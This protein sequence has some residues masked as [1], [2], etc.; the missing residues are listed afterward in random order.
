MSS[1]ILSPTHRLKEA[2]SPVGRTPSELTAM[3]EADLTVSDPGY[4]MRKLFP[5]IVSALEMTVALIANHG[6]NPNACETLMAE[7]LPGLTSL[8][9]E[10]RRCGGAS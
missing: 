8:L 6:S 3:M 2:D 4:A 1:E 5:R 9:A 7:R 10:A